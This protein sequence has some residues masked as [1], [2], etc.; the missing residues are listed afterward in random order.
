MESYT[1]EKHKEQSAVFQKQD[2][3]LHEEDEG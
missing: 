3:V 2:A 1:G